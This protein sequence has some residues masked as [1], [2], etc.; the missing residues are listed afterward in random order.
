MF[1]QSSGNVYAD[2]G[3]EDPQGM[4]IKANVVAE[5]ATVIKH[6][7]WSVQ[8]AA[9]ILGTQETALTRILSGKFRHVPSQNLASMR[10][11]ATLS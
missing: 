11:R 9:T 2:L 5:L 3:Y 4:Q 8:Q 10:D 1:E 6:R 7:Q